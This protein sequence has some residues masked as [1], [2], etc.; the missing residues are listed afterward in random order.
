[1]IEGKE[2]IVVQPPYNS[3]HVSDDLAKEIEQQSEME[4]AKIITES[5]NRIF[6]E[7][8]LVY[9]DSVVTSTSPSE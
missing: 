9:V 1:M 8:G 3:N 2:K 5:C 7:F 4:R 6:K